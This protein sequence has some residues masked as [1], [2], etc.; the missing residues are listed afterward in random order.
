VKEKVEFILYQM[1]LV[2][3]R[4]GFVRCQILS[5]KITKRHLNEAGPE[6]LKIQYFKYMIQ[7]YVHEKDILN[8]AKAYQII[9][10]TVN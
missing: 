5:K 6:A 1:Q 10:D 3:M 8:A 4:S 2:L 9:F 7:H